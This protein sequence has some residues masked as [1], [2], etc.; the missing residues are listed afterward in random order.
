MNTYIE[1]MVCPPISDLL[2]V[3]YYWKN[4]FYNSQWTAFSYSRP[5]VPGFGKT[6]PKKNPFFSRIGMGN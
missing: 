6:F 5:D 3:T 2:S 4:S 1:A